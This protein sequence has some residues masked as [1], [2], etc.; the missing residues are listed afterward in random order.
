MQITTKLRRISLFLFSMVLSSG[1]LFA[2]E[3]TVT[4]KV[5]AEGEGAVPGVNVTIQGTTIVAMT[6]LDGSYSLRVPGP[7]SV[8]VFSSIGYVTQAITVGSQTVINVNL[9]SDVQALQEVV[10][11]GYTQQRKRDL[12][13][14][15]GVVETDELT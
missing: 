14:A 4:G 6:G 3:R 9:V 5:T 1:I 7:T 13:G 8:L 2:Q 12:T 10:V 11:T 15:V